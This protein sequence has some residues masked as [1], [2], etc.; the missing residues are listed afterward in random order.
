MKY[1][2]GLDI[3]IASVGWAAMLLNQEDEPCRILDMGVRVFDKAENPK[4]GASL[5][6]PRRENR[7]SRRRNRRHRHRLERIKLLI[8]QY[9]IMECSQI[10][11]LYENPQ[12]TED[13]YALRCK[14]LDH[15]LDKQA[16]VRVLIHLAQ[17]RGFQ[18]NRKAEA[19][20]KGTDDGKLLAATKAN[21]LLMAEKGYRTVGEM[22]YKDEKFA[23][24]KRNK[25]EN[26]TN[27]VTRSEIAREAAAIFTAQRELGNPFATEAFEKGY[28]E[29]LLSQRNFDEGPG[30]NSKYGG[31]QIEKM[32]GKCTFEQGEPRAFK[33]QYSFEYCNLLQKINAM[34]IGKEKRPLSQLE[35]KQLIDMAFSVANPS[36]ATIRKKLAIPENE[37]FHI[38][39]GT[40][41]ADTEKKTKFTYLQSYH[42]L[43]KAYGDS[44]Q[45]MSRDQLNALGYV[46]SAYK[47][48]FKISAYLADKGF[49]QGEIEVALSIPPFS[50]SGNLSVKA[51]DKLIPYLEE[52][53]TYDKA[54]AAA[55]YDFKREGAV[56]KSF[57]L[58]ASA[59]ELEDISNPVVRRAVSQTI[60]VVNGIIRKYGESPCFVSVELARELAR[61]F[62][63]RK[64]IEKEQKENFARN[65]NLVEEI[66]NNFKGVKPSGINLMKLKLW[67]EQDGR[68]IYSQQPIEYGRLFEEG[69][70]DIDHIV[71]YSISFDDSIHNKVLVHTQE[72]RQ[73]GNRLPLQYLKNQDEFTVRV[74]NT[75]RNRKKRDFL[76][77]E[78]IADK[79]GFKERNLSDTKYIS[80]FIYNYIR[81]HLQMHPN[82]TGQKRTV[83]AVNGKITYYMRKRWGLSK[84]R[85][86]GD[87]HH[88]VD[89]VVVACTTQ[90]MI[91]KIS[92]YTFYHETKST[93]TVDGHVFDVERSTGQ[94][95][96]RFPLP[97]PSF[98]R[99]LEMRCSNDPMY[100]EPEKNY[101]YYL[102]NEEVKPIFVSRMP[103][104]K[105][106]GQA[107]EETVR[108]GKAIGDGYKIS[109]VPLTSLKLDQDGGV[110]GYFNPSSD[111]VL[112]EAIRAK[113]L[114]NSG[115]GDKAFAEPFYKPKSD[116]T[117]G[118]LVKKVKIMESA[119]LA[120]SLPNGIADNGTMLRI[121]VFYVAGEGYYFVPIYI[122]DTVKPD[123]PRKAVVARK[124]YEDWREMSDDDFVFSLYP[125]DL[126][127]VTA[128]KQQK[129]SLINADSTLP[130]E[131]FEKEFFVYYVSA[132]ISSASI[133]I[134]TQDSTYKIESFGIKTV[135]LIEKYEVD[136]LGNVKKAGKEKRM[137]F[138]K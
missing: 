117:Q 33:A 118:P 91:H 106:T 103:R 64:R 128:K 70:V 2:I 110:K 121:D 97:Y 108:S 82:A 112:Y 132:G 28:L 50:K 51:C 123:L 38:S 81:N 69:Y 133:K 42:K 57:Y 55:G 35:R 76:L 115:K 61:S 29:I 105:N 31:N 83:L 37:L 54:C 62:Q 22:L 94:V 119:T 40:D 122:S 87:K 77:M 73:K 78:E 5:A 12:F 47:N 104:H 114:A 16:F 113:L 126:I 68:C 52:G 79:E 95:T 56:E 71:P 80:T 46:L 124:G 19:Q 10:K 131:H 6:L 58:P 36:F 11:S 85:A 98:R 138:R 120:V 3:G 63:D 59:P 9:G 17:R 53:L 92:D 129:F 32:L 43:K 15:P 84:I 60:K 74:K 48:D 134:I 102:K 130:P 65:E 137:Y 4:N 109:K 25:A 100:C 90:G 13:V 99:E 24:C 127:R 21:E 93:I 89:A 45:S 125:N 41:L 116:G 136:V 66:E 67:K 14:G 23:A 34:R 75:V 18:S 27:T 26:Y 1:R 96:D 86:D 7:G 101:P 30:G 49:S 135:P 88:A 107:H 111:R 44:I 8:E 72:N 39:Y 20:N